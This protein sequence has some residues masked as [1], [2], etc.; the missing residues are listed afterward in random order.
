LFRTDFFDVQFQ[1]MGASNFHLIL[2]NKY[3]KIILASSY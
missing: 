1:N 3:K 2:L